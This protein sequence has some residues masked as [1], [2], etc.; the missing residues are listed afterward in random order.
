MRKQLLKRFRFSVRKEGQALLEAGGVQNVEVSHG[1]ILGSVSQTVTVPPGADGELSVDGELLA[2]EG[3]VYT[4]EPSYC[5]EGEDPDEIAPPSRVEIY[6]EEDLLM[7]EPKLVSRCSCD[8]PELNGPCYHQWALIQ[9]CQKD[10]LLTKMREEF[11]PS[12]L[13]RSRLEQLERAARGRHVNPWSEV[14]ELH[15]RIRYLFDVSLSLD[16]DYLYL[17]TEWQKR[18]RHGGW[19]QAKRIAI[20]APERTRFGEVTDRKLTDLLSP[21]GVPESP[22]FSQARRLGR[23]RLP[24]AAIT[25]IMQLA[26]D[27]GRVFASRSGRISSKPLSWDKGEPWIIAPRIREG[28]PRISFDYFLKR[29]E[30]E[31]ELT[32]EMFLFAGDLL[33]TGE[34]FLR[35]NDA[36]PWHVV[37]SVMLGGPIEVPTKEKSRLLQVTSIFNSEESGTGEA[38]PD[39]DGIAPVPILSVTTRVE[40]GQN[41]EC[42]VRFSYA[43][44]IIAAEDTQ[45]VVTLPS[46]RAVRRAEALEQKALR[47]FLEVGG[48][49]EQHTENSPP[50]PTLAP[51][52]LQPATRSLLNQGWQLD[53]AG[54]R[55]H[56]SGKT[57]FAITSGIDWFD[58]TGTI[59]FSG[60]EVPL[61]EILAASRKGDHFF[62]LP[63]GSIGLLPE[64][65]SK[66]WNLIERLGKSSDG[67]IRFGKSQGW[68]LDA[69]LSSQDAQVATD[70]GYDALRNRL[71]Q[72]GHAEPR[73][74]VESFQGE[75]RKYQREG[76]GWINALQE[77]GLGGCLAD[78]MGLGKTV[79]VLA[80]LEDRRASGSNGKPSLVVAPKSLVFNWEREAKRFAPDLR[81]MCYGGP[82]RGDLLA[83]MKDV[84]LVITT[85]GTLRRDIQELREVDFDYA[86]LDE[87]QAIKNN[88]S[89]ISK[90]VRLLRSDHRLALSGTPIEN[91]L[92]EL[93]SIF[94]FLNP[95][96][97][98][99]S[100]SFKRL[101]AGKR[102]DRLSPEDRS[103]IAGALRPFLLRRRKED[104][105]PDLPEKSEQIIYCDLT[106][107]QRTDY[108]ELREYYRASLLSAKEPFSSVPRIHVLEALLRL[109]Q[110]SCHPAL[111]D[112]TRIEEPSAKFEV[113]LPML[114]ELR[115]EGHKALIFSQFTQHLG[116]LRNL[117]DR[118]EFNYTYLDGRTRKR[119]ERVDEFQNNPKCTLFLISLKAGGHGLNL[120][121][122]DYVFLLDPWWNPA[123]ESQAI[124]RSHRI[125]Q[126]RKV[127]AY[128]LISRDTTEEKVL[129]LQERKRSLANAILSRDNAVLRDLTREDLELLLS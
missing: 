5:P 15:G 62:E 90:A 105:L 69:L 45:P 113:L 71:G 11:V 72:V 122:A 85:Y 2:E 127:M 84:Q 86:I 37:E 78:D 46:G 119:E 97:L 82:E 23:S 40:D 59:N 126:T 94:E 57:N 7:D 92:G 104:V 13:W 8:A 22:E 49:L 81:V 52:L 91:H 88:S 44:E 48:S 87:A 14:G 24:G 4:P 74:E 124:D 110:A 39:S 31:R 21:F 29:D 20:D 100:T 128:R 129:D 61:P 58:V 120:T 55:I 66:Q 106:K 36:P 125:G 51:K 108:D 102:G 30:E 73:H 56:T 25:H 116:A 101:F 65:G 42:A 109:R 19:N 93:W 50:R 60:T 115:E 26:C 68:L 41:F 47:L 99:R 3:P 33:F 18:N 121:A 75:L 16:C 10:G 118:N 35:V 28:G 80:E 83:Q 70:A 64:E 6:F 17:T 123:A 1:H 96:M 77:L 89:Q 54:S 12:A 98:G 32:A 76:L 9:H 111:L 112:P 95:G 63:D 107:R 114:E 43:G 38:E 117:L 67:A 53:L 34:G 27:T 103:R 79:Q